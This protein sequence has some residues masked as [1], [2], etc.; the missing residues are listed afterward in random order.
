MMQQDEFWK[1]EHLS[2]SQLLES[3]NRVVR[4][5]RRALAELIAHLGEVEE[6]RLHLEAAH[7]SMFDYCVARLGMSEDEACRRIDLARL[8]RRY[9]ALYPL[10]ASG[11]IT[12]SVALV[13]KPILSQANHHELFAAARGKS[14]LEARELVALH[15][16]RSDVP[17]GIRKLPQPRGAGK[18]ASTLGLPPIAS[19]P[20]ASIPQLQAHDA[21]VETSP[22]AQPVTPHVHHQ[23]RIEPLSPQRYKVQ[24][25][26]DKATKDQLEQ[27]RDLL[28]HANPSG[29]FGPI[30][31][32]A[33]EL[34][35][36]DLLR[37]RFGAGACRKAAS[38]RPKPSAS[39]APVRPMDET[40]VP[41]AS[42]EPS[43]SHIP[44]AARRAVLE[45]DGLA[46][47][48]RDADGKRCGSRAWLEIDHRHPRG[49]G[50][51][52]E[53]ENLRILCRA[54]NDLA[55]EH[56]YGRAHM[57]QAKR[58]QHQRTVHTPFPHRASTHV[59]REPVN[60]GR[61]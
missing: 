11:E 12:L 49:K 27:A 48:W 28:R 18:D 54:H 7:S 14:I 58:R 53:P 33:L 51:G 19:T 52:S 46:C 32:R 20:P 30:L 9:P 42:V 21:R 37:R 38:A 50:G 34:L 61:V 35:I 17:F 1:L 43:G 45:R 26:I 60:A 15:T 44:R 13:L 2:H 36:A 23:S 5:R 8:A 3:L 31:A 59:T 29:D 39:Q 22:S 25:T 24:F 4:I 41:A 10:L 57:Q 55:A 16:P 6:R 40:L 56:E 47:T